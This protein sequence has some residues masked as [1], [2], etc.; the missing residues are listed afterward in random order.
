M[1]HPRAPVSNT[2]TN[3]HPPSG[4]RTPE[5]AK[6]TLRKLTNRQALPSGAH[7]ATPDGAATK[8]P[9]AQPATTPS[10]ASPHSTP[11]EPAHTHSTPATALTLR[12][13]ASLN[14]TATTPAGD[15]PKTT[16]GGPTK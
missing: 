10:Q 12:K 14:S 3:K 11:T 16:T 15:T 1:N 6:T 2:Q 9:T 8:Q 7:D 5:A 4:V 13:L